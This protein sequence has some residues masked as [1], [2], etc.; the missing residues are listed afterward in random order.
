[1]RCCGSRKNRFC[2]RAVRLWR[3][4]SIRVI[5]TVCAASVVKRGAAQAAPLFTTL[6]AHTRL[7]RVCCVRRHRCQRVRAF[8]GTGTGRGE[9]SDGSESAAIAESQ[10]KVNENSP[11]TPGSTRY[12]RKRKGAV[13]AN[14]AR[15][16]RAYHW[17]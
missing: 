12:R 13:D 17:R 6:A 9:G 7:Q 11:R 15:R 5:M 8:A 4:T 2:C 1:M 10:V 16:I 14:V 3:L